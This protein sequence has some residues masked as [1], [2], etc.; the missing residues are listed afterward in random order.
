MSE[1]MGSLGGG[2][3]G[4]V[5][6]RSSVSGGG[7][8]AHTSMPDDPLKKKKKDKVAFTPPQA[9]IPGNGS[10][11]RNGVINESYTDPNTGRDWKGTWN[12]W[13]DEGG[14]D[15]NLG[16][17]SFAQD[18]SKE[19]FYDPTLPPGYKATGAQP[20][21]Q[22]TQM[23]MEALLALLNP[24]GGGGRARTPS[25]GGTRYVNGG[26]YANFLNRGNI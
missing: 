7:S 10:G 24:G 6:G 19:P 2:G 17:W 26:G 5:G 1:G 20:P 16:F 11:R 21:S 18:P 23:G 9:Y 14:F 15:P 25:I 8:S 3:G 22:A 4:F 13:N 12:P